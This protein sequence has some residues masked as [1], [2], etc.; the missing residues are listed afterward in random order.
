MPNFVHF[1]RISSLRKNYNPKLGG[2]SCRILGAGTSRAATPASEKNGR[3][4][5]LMKELPEAIE[6]I[7]IV[8]RN[9]VLAAKTANFLI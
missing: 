5:L 6:L 4:L 1:L 8:D 9:D 3:T 7:S 2:F